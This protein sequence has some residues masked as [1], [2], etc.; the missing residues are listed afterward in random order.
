MVEHPEPI[1]GR[2]VVNLV[3]SVRRGAQRLGV[4]Q[5]A[6]ERDRNHAA[7]RTQVG[8]LPRQHTHTIASRNQ[9]PHDIASDESVAA[10]D[11]DSPGHRMIESSTGRGDG[12]GPLLTAAAAARP[13]ITALS[14]VAGSPVWT[15][16]PARNKLWIGVARRAQARCDRGSGAMVAC[17]S[18]ITSA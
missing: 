5:V 16:S 10:G 7:Q 15:Q 11:E 17:F 3:A 2:D 12:L 8:I 14:I 6:D 9:R 4:A 1:I 18:L 13:E